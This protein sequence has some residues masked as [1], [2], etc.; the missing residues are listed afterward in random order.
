MNRQR[1]TLTVVCAA[2]AMLMLDIAVVNTAV[3]AIARDLH[4]GFQS[5]QWIVDA[6]TVALAATVLTAGSLA[7]R[8]GRRRTFGVGLVLFTV[9]SA[10]CGAATSI[11][12]LDGFR[13]VQGVG[14]AIL[15]ATSLA[16]IRDAYPEPAS[17]G[18]AFAA[19]GAT[20][21]ASFAVGPLVGGML[22][23]WLDWR[24]IFFLHVPL[25]IAAL[26]GLCPPPPPPPPP[27]PP[28]RPGRPARR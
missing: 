5:I 1:L 23:S 10:A 11:T 21:G 28:P 9:M 26:A 3:P 18:N 17:R 8:L 12:M 22:T 7:D 25:G 16:L 6:Y 20:I 14:A 13:A 2:T 27:G 24:A 19:Y 4:A 15:F